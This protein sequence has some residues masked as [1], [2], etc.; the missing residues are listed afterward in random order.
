MFGVTDITTYVIGVVIIVL[1]PGPNSM[2]VLSVA[3]RGGVAAGY[4]AACG[5]FVGDLVLMLAAAAGMASVLQAYPGL[6]GVFKLAGAA[7]LAWLGI[8]LLR[9]A[10]HSWHHGAEAQ[11]IPA[12]PLSMT[13]PFTRALTISLLNP[14]A[15]L[16]FVSF[17]IQFVDRSYAHPALTYAVLGGIVQLASFS[18]LTALIF[19]GHRLAAKLRA[20]HRM[21]AGANG[22]VGALFLTF[23]ARLA[24]AA[25]G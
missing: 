17:F 18:Y 19:A 7:Y 9:S 24:T 14:K 25:A 4:R 22:G 20:R 13:R 15:I 5:V 3:G 12:R 21:S 6:F 1:L 10:W 16:F 2:F 11:A 8:G 23:S